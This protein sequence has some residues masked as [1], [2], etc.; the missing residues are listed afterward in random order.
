LH[1]EFTVHLLN[2]EGIEKAQM[3]ATVFDDALTE[4]E[5]LCLRPASSGGITLPG[6]YENGRE[7]AIVRTKLEEASFF[8][9]KALALLPENQKS[10][11]Q[12]A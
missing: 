7:F 10:A 12:N 8:A 3:I 1:R 2:P 11:A 6:H 9:K 4:L 5:Q